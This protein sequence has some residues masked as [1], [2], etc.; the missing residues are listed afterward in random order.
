MTL[1]PLKEMEKERKIGVGLVLYVTSEMRFQTDDTENP[2]SRRVR[3]QG[4]NLNDLE[5]SKIGTGKKTREG[6]VD[7]GIC[8]HRGLE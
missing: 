7:T 2:T 5:S 1:L 4:G 8:G 3:M 6:M